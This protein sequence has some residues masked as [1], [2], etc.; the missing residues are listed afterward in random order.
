MLSKNDE[1]SK[2]DEEL[3]ENLKEDVEKDKITEVSGV[4]KLVLKVVKSNFFMPQSEWVLRSGEYMLGRH[5]S[6]DIIIPDPYVSRRHA[7][8]FFRDGDWFIEDLDSTNGTILNKENI[9][10]KGPQKI[11][12]NSEIVIGLTIIKANLV[13]D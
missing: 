10:G 4:K 8:I 2:A 13:E 7:R 1:P 6:N 11:D 3:V 9:K 5:P 12:N